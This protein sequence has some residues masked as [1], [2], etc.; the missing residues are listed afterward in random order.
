MPD[1]R[2][3]L[4][5]ATA[6]LGER[7]DAELLLLHV[8]QQS[9]SWLFTHADDAMAMD[10]HGQ[11]RK[12]DTRYADASVHKPA[13]KAKTFQPKDFTF[14]RELG[15]CVCPAKQTLKLNDANALISGRK[16]TVFK[17]TTATCEACTLRSQCLRKPDVTAVRQVAT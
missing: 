15:T 17:G 16:A 13:S 5:E 4:A 11:M 1:V 7:V 9:R 8:L 12:R 3:A 2:G 10:V 6:Q 14:D